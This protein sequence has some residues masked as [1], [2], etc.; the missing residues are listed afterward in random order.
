MTPAK[1]LKI[2]IFQVGES[3]RRG[4]HLGSR[5]YMIGFKHGAVGMKIGEIREAK[6]LPNLTCHER[7]ID[8]DLSERA[9]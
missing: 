8:P 7:K 3:R 9:V 2:R 1:G 4:D 5:D 6:E